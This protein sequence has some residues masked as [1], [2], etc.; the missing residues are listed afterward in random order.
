MGKRISGIGYAIEERD[1]SN[2]ENVKSKK[3]TGQTSRKLGHHE[4]SKSGG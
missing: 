4:K 2:K 1:T 3:L